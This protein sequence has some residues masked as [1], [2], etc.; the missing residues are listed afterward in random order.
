MKN[1]TLLVSKLAMMMLGLVLFAACSDDDGPQYSNAALQNSELKAVLAQKGFQFNEQGNLLLDDKATSTTSLDLSGTN[2]PQSA[3]AELSILPNLTDVNLSNNGYGDTFDF[4]NL[5]AQIT[6]I[7][8]T[9]N[10]IYNYDN[11]VK[12]TVAENGDETVEQL[13]NITKLYLPNE[14]KNNI[15]QLVRFY[16]QNKSAIDAGTMDVEMVN[17]SG[18]LEKYN[19]LREIPDEVL[20]AYLN[21]ETTFSEL[22]DGERIDISKT[23]SNSAKIN[24]IYVTKDFVDNY[25]NLQ[26]LEGLQYIINNP[27]WEG[28]TIYISPSTTLSLPKVEIGS[29]LTL[30]QLKKVDVSQGLDISKAVNLTDVNVNE[31]S[32]LKVLDLRPNTTWGQRGSSVEEDGMNGSALY[33]VDCA[34]LEEIYLPSYNGLGMKELDIEVLPKLKVLDMSNISMIV[35]LEIGDLSEDFNLIYPNLTVFNSGSGKTAFACSTQTYSLASTVDF[36]KKYYKDTTDK[37]LS[38]SVNLTSSKNKAAFWFI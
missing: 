10:E 35:C 20:R 11:L 12:V 15:A 30:L 9:G 38:I 2:L 21:Q 36:V 4:A 19:T 31:V 5:P 23:L 16:R 1:L 18:T 6:G 25:A 32:G 3:L 14:A 26:N 17:T 8:L 7:D 29:T 28:T 24:N 27:Y 22:F 37:K 34:D 33:C 13:H